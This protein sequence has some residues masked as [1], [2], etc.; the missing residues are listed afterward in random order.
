M[1]ELIN[2]GY[3]NSHQLIL[4]DYWQP[5][6]QMTCSAYLEV[7]TDGFANIRIVINGI[8]NNFFRGYNFIILLNSNLT[9]L[10]HKKFLKF[11]KSVQK[12]ITSIAN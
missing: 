4:S 8:K 11:F 1:I 2:D 3:C 10:N 6:L 5:Y 12:E 9:S 7:S